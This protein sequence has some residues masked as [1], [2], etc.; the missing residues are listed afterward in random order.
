M[1]EQLALPFVTRGLAQS[2][3]CA[4]GDGDPEYAG[5]HHCPRCAAAVAASVAWM[6]DAIARGDYDEQGYTLA[7]RRAQ[8]R[9]QRRRVTR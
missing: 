2:G 4:F 5:P 7:E 3:P 1:T 6:R 9:Q 8:T